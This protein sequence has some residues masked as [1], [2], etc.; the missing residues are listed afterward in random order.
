M[1]NKLIVW[2]EQR[3]LLKFEIYDGEVVSIKR[4]MDSNNY[5][6]KTSNQGVNI[7]TIHDLES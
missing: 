1:S 6:I 4:V 5:I 7:L 3:D 2:D